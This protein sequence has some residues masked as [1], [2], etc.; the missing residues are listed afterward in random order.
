ML[1]DLLFPSSK[2]SSKG[3]RAGHARRG[4]SSARQGACAVWNLRKIAASCR[5]PA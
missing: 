3:R 5:A 4:Q 2:P 1:Y